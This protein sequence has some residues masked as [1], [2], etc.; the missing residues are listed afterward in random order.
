MAIGVL[1]AT[2][3]L[4][5]AVQFED[6]VLRLESGVEHPAAFAIALVVLE[7]GV[8]V[9]LILPTSR[10]LAAAGLMA[11]CGALVG[12]RSVLGVERSCNCLG[13]QSPPW[14]G[15]ALLLLLLSYGLLS[16]L[17][18]RSR[19]RLVASACGLLFLALGILGPV[20]DVGSHAPQ[21]FASWRDGGLPHE[22]ILEVHGSGAHLRVT[23]AGSSCECV[24]VR[25]IGET[26]LSIRFV[27]DVP[28]DVRPVI[29]V[30]ALVDGQVRRAQF[31]V[32]R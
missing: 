32:P 19:N 28:H 14:L 17:K 6:F 5:K 2:I 23:E 18:L 8:G 25:R 11:L 31:K 7:A 27:H 3:A 15:E 4:V 16:L 1:L 9:L 26:H 22:R 20:V 13:A 10:L 12:G 30:R 29:R 21:L 24:E